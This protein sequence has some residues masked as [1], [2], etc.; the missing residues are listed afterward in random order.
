MSRRDELLKI[1]KDLDENVLTI[2]TPMVD[3][4][5]FVEGQLVELKKMPF[6]RV[7]PDD[8]SKQKSTAAYKVYKDLLSQ[9]RE[10]LRMLLMSLRKDGDG[11]GESPL[12]AYLNSL[13]SRKV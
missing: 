3:E 6:V 12:R 7:H 9:E 5:I 13:E 2:V 1:F 8:V 11:D 10:I 4:L